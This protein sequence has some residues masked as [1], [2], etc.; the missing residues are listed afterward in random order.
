MAPPVSSPGD[1]LLPRMTV[2]NPLKKWCLS[3]E[4]GEPDSRALCPWCIFSKTKGVIDVKKAGNRFSNGT[5]RCSILGTKL[6]NKQTWHSHK[7]EWQANALDQWGGREVILGPW[8]RLR[9]PGIIL[10]AMGSCEMVLVFVFA[11]SDLRLRKI[12]LD[13][14]W[15]RMLREGGADVGSQR[16]RCGPGEKWWLF[17]WHW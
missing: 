7:T 9:V 12:P 15:R 5:N 13:G 6:K 2:L 1:T 8:A 17:G 10:A 3:W 16:T 4:S 14:M 11:W